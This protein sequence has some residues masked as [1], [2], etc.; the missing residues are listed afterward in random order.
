MKYD[1]F[2]RELAKAGLT[3]RE[4][5]EIVKMNRNSLSNLSSRGDVPAHLAV[6]ASLMGEMTE[7]RVD[8][9]AVLHR[10]VIAQKKPRAKKPATFNRSRR[11][12]TVDQRAKAT[13]TGGEI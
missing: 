11:Q 7:H 8:F 13:T 4:F 6:I 5:A 2:R 3:I 1:D 10:V 9:R 12:S